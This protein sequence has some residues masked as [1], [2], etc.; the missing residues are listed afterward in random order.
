MDRYCQ[1]E[2]GEVGRMG[3]RKGVPHGT[4]QV[5]G[6]F[7]FSPPAS[8]GSSSVTVS[9]DF[10]VFNDPDICVLGLCPGIL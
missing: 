2:C 5:D 10:F 3:V 8:L 9:L 1:E 4:G 7:A 6:H